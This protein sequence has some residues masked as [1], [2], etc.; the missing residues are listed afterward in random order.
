MNNTITILKRQ[1]R[2]YFRAPLGYVLMTA[3]LLI[4]GL[5][6]CR[7]LADNLG[8]HI[9][10]G[11]LLFAVW[12]F[13]A[14]ALAAV[15]LIAMPLL[16]EEKRSG[17]LEMLLTAPVTDTQVVLG[18]YFGALLFFLILC[19][20]T[21]LY[22]MIFCFFA[23]GAT[24]L[25]L[26]PILTGYLVLLLIGGCYLALGLFVSALTRSQGAAA[27]IGIT[28]VALLAFVDLLRWVF[29]EIGLAPVFEQFSALTHVQEFA[30]GIVDSR[31]VVLY[32]SVTAFFLFGTIK[33]LETRQW[34]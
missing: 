12:P 1:L 3:F 14:A 10:P 28:A 13:W 26:A 31:P 16:A 8:A 33:I 17:T 5:S 34:K 32:L 27:M 15:A 23:S 20:P 25:M 4:A 24:G 18:K 29:P 11:A 22:F 9:P 2:A 7:T 21:S 6:F 30:R 19:L